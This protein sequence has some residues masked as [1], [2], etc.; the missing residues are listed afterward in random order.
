MFLLMIPVKYQKM[1]IRKRRPDDEIGN[2]T[3]QPVATAPALIILFHDFGCDDGVKG[4]YPD[5]CRF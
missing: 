5:L 4:H 1:M 2:I 3:Y